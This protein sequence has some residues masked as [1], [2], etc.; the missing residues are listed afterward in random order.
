MN[1]YQPGLDLPGD[2]ARIA[3]V[4]WTSDL[5]QVVL[6]VPDESGKGTRDSERCSIRQLLHELEDEGITDP[7]INSHEVHAPL[8]AEVGN[9]GW[10]PNYRD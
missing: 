8:A 7:S 10:G 2:M 4:L 5:Q 9:Q 6:E 3:P 1:S